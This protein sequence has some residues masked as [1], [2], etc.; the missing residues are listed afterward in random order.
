MTRVLVQ[1]TWDDAPHLTKEQKESLWS[2]I[3]IHERDARTKGLPVLGAGRIYPISEESL[4][5]KPFEFPRWWPRAYALD[6][7][8]N[9]TAALWG[10]WDRDGDT[11]YLFSEYYAGHQ[12]PAVHAS[13]IKA[14][15]E[16]LTGAIDPAAVGANQRDGMVLA[17]EYRELGLNLVLA[18]NKV[19]GP[20]GGIFA[21]EQ[22]MARG[23]IK[24]F[25]TLRN[26]LAEFRIYRRDEHGKIVKEND[27]LM[28][29]MRYLIMT[30]MRFASIEPEELEEMEQR[31]SAYGRNDATGY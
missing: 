7:G 6:V 29:C 30:G 3:P 4:L 11:V 25:N 28:D 13:G 12:H 9:R 18:D 20:E 8:W 15:G 16:W 1:A 31:I 10:A 5:V 21:C 2:S 14:R 23:G 26:W 17:N 24:V 22:R 19:N 27:H